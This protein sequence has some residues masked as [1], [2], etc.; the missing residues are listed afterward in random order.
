M[1]ANK[2][3]RSQRR[4]AHQAPS[5]FAELD[6]EPG[7]GDIFSQ[8]GI[9]C[10]SPGWPDAAGN[11]LRQAA[12]ESLRPI[13]TLSLFSGGGG[14][15]IGFHDAG[16]EIGEAVE[17]DPRCV[18]VLARNAGKRKSL[19]STSVVGCDI[20]DYTPNLKA[21]YEFVIG[22]PPCQSFS[23]AGRRASGVTGINDDRGTLFEE[24][25]RILKLVK[26]RG[27]LFENV[28]GITG[29]NGGTAWRTVC[30]SF[31]E[32]GYNISHRIL[33]AADYGVPQHRDRAIIVGFRDGEF[34]FPR[35]TH[36]PDS[37]A[38]RP[39]FAAGVAISGV[40]VESESPTVVNGRYGHLLAEVPAGLNYSFFTEQMGHPR[41]VFAWR[42]KFSDF[43]YKADPSA[44]IR[45]LK[46]QGGQYTGPFLASLI[47]SR[48]GR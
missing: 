32:A 28:S 11:A 5:L 47:G 24:F 41:P 45:T 44:P 20:R 40:P 22:G 4:T 26:P 18:A 17:V 15:D 21:G 1:G 16:F 12:T 43:L 38:G 2:S 30:R 9:D 34:Q 25:V 6:A 13:P 33:D 14:L 3:A 7:S 37:L 46:A 42:S 27:F 35:P 19:G 10:A 23:A 48:G 8:L 36:G 29:A 39:H 31:A